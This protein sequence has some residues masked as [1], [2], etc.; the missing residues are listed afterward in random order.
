MLAT[1]SRFCS[2]SPCRR[3]LSLSRRRVGV[4]I[5]RRVR[6]CEGRPRRRA[7]GVRVRA[8]ALQLPRQGQRQRPKD[9]GR[10]R[11]PLRAQLR[12]RRGHQ[13]CILRE[14]RGRAASDLR[15]SRQ[16]RRHVL[17]RPTR[18]ALDARALDYEHPRHET[19]EPARDGSR[20]YVTGK[21]FA[22][23]FDLENGELLWFVDKFPG[24]KEPSSTP[25]TRPSRAGARFFS[26]RARSTMGRARTVFVNSKTGK[27]VRVE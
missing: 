11:A 21:N 9:E 6:A 23:A 3:S 15:S 2:R 12:P 25:S 4:E 10:R 20:L 7:E 24:S 17:R 26:G 5:L 16:V 14:V 18:P 27:I 22:G 8:R 19:G 1:R 13:V